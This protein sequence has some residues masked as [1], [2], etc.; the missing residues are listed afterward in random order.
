[1]Q[2]VCQLT[3]LLAPPTNPAVG[4]CA[5]CA[6]RGVEYQAWR[7]AHLLVSFAGAAVA[8]PAIP[9]GPKESE[10]NGVNQSFGVSHSSRSS[11]EAGALV[12]ESWKHQV[13]LR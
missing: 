11:G 8:W 4:V 12:M 5:S 2:V 10:S 7:S 1:M 13:R 3:A 6:V 9:P